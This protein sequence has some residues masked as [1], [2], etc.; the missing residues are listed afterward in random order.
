MLLIDVPREK[1]LTE[2]R[3]NTSVLLDVEKV[4][5]NLRFRYGGF[6][7]IRARRDADGI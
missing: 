3:R 1:A 4:F 6:S 7:P 2:S 5:G